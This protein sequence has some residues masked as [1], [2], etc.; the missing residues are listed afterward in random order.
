KAGPP[1]VA[2]APRTREASTRLVQN[3]LFLLGG[4]LLGVAAI[5]FTAVAWAQFGVGGRALLL[6]G[7][8]VAA[9]AVPLAALRRNLRATAETFAAVGL[10][11]V[12]LDGY[13]AWY[14]NLF[15]VADHSAFGYAG[16]VCA[17]T[18]AVA[19]GYEHLTGLTGPRFA[20]LIVAQ[21]VLPLLAAPFHPDAAG[22]AYA[23]I[24]VAVLDLAV[25]HL[26]RSALSALGVTAYGLGGAAVVGAV[27]S[28]LGALAAAET[29]V[30]AALAALALVAGAGLAV[31]AA[32]LARVRPAQAITGGLF[33]VA[34]ALAAGRFAAV[35]GGSFL[36]PVLI[37]AVVATVAVLVTAVNRVLPEPV[38]RGPWAGALVVAAASAVVVAGVTVAGGYDWRVLAVIALVAAALVVLVPRVLQP[39]VLLGGAALAAFAAPTALGLAWW[40]A[41]VLDLI[42]VAAALVL[43]LRGGGHLR[44]VAGGIPPVWPATV[45]AG[46]TVHAVV[47]ALGSPGV[48]CATLV[49]VAA[50]GAGTAAA[51]RRAPGP[52]GG[53]A[54]TA[55]LL[56]LPAAAWTGAAALSLPA[57]AQSRAALAVVALLTGAAQ[58][59]GRGYRAYALAAVLIGVVSAPAWALA[60]GDSPAIYAACG[61]L[62]VALSFVVTIWAG[63]AALPLGLVLFGTTAPSLFAVLVRPY[64]WLDRVWTG[65]PG[66]TGV[67]A[68]AVADVAA[69]AVFAVAVAVAVRSARGVRAAVWAVAPVVAVL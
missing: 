65:V 29:T 22:W 31:A 28:A 8:T 4:L 66:G 38:R 61:L 1:P 6:A 39:Q 11:L 16:A 35:A 51:A 58:L 12:L 52:L 3:V 30:D 7:F 57:T 53:V 50:L 41:P 56:A 33:V 46:F 47:V 43:A 42:V 45:A 13:A 32:V 37:A 67:G 24:G 26:R 23:L 40:A 2:P 17:V 27:L 59:I 14:V 63:L 62:L 18:A 34:L 68:V 54:L 55:G 25:I 69:L 48:A 9:L 49:A 10:L 19:A 5:V 15:G 21:P 64:G 20:A 44:A 36:A 60:S